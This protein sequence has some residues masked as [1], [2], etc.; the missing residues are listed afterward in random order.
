MLVCP[1]TNTMKEIFYDN[2]ITFINDVNLNVTDAEKITLL[3]SGQRIMKNTATFII[4]FME[5]RC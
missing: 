5:H 1:K 4:T 3:L 2:V